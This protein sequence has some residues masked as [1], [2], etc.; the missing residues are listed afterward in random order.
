MGSSKYKTATKKKSHTFN[1]RALEQSEWAHMN[2]Y[3]GRG[4]KAWCKHGGKTNQISVQKSRT[5]NVN[6]VRHI[7]LHHSLL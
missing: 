2:V 1:T 6:P 3:G 5:S 7:Q 4:E